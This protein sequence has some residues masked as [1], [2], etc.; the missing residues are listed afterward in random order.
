MYLWEYLPFKLQLEYKLDLELWQKWRFLRPQHQSRRY[1]SKYFG[2]IRGGFA[3]KLPYHHHISIFNHIFSFFCLIAKLFFIDAFTSHYSPSSITKYTR[4]CYVSQCKFR[5]LTSVGFYYQRLHEPQDDTT[6][7]RKLR[8][9][10]MLEY[11]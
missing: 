8:W 10:D 5:M 1:S 4:I 6:S 7:I 9:D 3:V 2:W 11:W